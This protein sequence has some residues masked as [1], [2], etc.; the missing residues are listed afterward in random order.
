[1]K[2]K[3]IAVLIK[4]I[5]KKDDELLADISLDELE[6]LC[7]TDEIEILCRMIQKRENIETSTYIG[8]GKL[9]ELK[10]L[11][12]SNDVNV[13]IADDELSP[14]Q[15]NEISEAIDD[16]KVLDRSMLILDIFAKHAVS[17][18]GKIQVELAQLQ[19]TVPR[20]YGQ[21]KNLSRLGGG[22][23][24]RGPGETKLETDKR[25]V[26]RRIN[27]L[28]EKIL[29]I[30]KNRNTQRLQRKK[31]EIFEIAI[32]GY[33][34]AGKSTLLNALTN[35]NVLAENKLFATLDT[36]TR[37]YKLSNGDE[38]LF[39]DTVG[40]I[41]NLP[42]QFIDAFKS[43]LDELKYADLI[44]IVI[45]SSDPEYETQIEVTEKLIGELASGDVPVLYV[46]NKIDLIE[47]TSDIHIKDS[48]KFV[49][50]SAK[51]MTGFDKLD[52]KII[53]IKNQNK[54]ERIYKIP[55]AKSG[56][57][58]FI[59]KNA[60]VKEVEYTNNDIIVKAITNDVQDNKINSIL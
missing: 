29:E 19:Y 59:Y 43:T 18:E 27:S 21:G 24:T 2:E 35:A 44:L 15:I 45:D 36:T 12:T 13:I 9:N 39:T 60:I 42:H 22:I 7:E 25:H 33:T 16:I 41:R 17:N 30:E 4:V 5:D 23:G 32:V 20:L 58:D 10:E 57:L 51:N 48:N 53:E 3:D 14:V 47:D 8:S 49:E 37:K 54:K 46:F 52:N 31:S 1:M 38:V 28:K 11:C 40:F 56:T 6:L 55:F 34:N 50:I 26:K